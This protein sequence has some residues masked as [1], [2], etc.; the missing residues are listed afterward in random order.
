[1]NEPSLAEAEQSL[2]FLLLKKNDLDEA[3]KHFEHA[4]QLDP[5]DATEFLRTRTRGH[6]ARPAIQGPR[7]EPSNA[8]E[9]ARR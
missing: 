6:G 1:M 2:G 8:F 5:M 3:Q 4:A 7:R 9:K